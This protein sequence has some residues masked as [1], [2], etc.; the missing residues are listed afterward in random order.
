MW[1]RL[2]Y[3][4]KTSHVL[5]ACE[6]QLCCGPN[7]GSCQSAASDL[8]LIKAIE[9]F[10][11]GKDDLRQEALVPCQLTVTTSSRRGQ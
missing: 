9:F 6:H 8:L 5:R 10:C 4:A 7:A 2:E 1:A 11:Q 3:L